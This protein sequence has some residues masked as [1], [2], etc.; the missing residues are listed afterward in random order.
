M[1]R[2]SRPYELFELAS[3]AVISIFIGL[4]LGGCTTP[5][6][7]SDRRWREFNPDYRQPYPED[8]RFF[9]PGIF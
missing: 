5:Q 7:E 2:P 4:L 3:L 1:T 9:R 6:I 8:P